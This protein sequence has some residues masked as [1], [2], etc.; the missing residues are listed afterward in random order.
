MA[1]NIKIVEN[2]TQTLKKFAM[3][4]FNKC[5][6]KMANFQLKIGMK[7]ICLVFFTIYIMI[8]QTFMKEIIKNIK[9]K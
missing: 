1:N 9:C 8:Q 5:I 6:K 7:N 4:I 2:S 3:N